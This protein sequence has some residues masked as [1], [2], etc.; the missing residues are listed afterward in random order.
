MYIFLLCKFIEKIKFFVTK[1]NYDKQ[2][3][4]IFTTRTITSKSGES[5]AIYAKYT[6]KSLKIKREG[7]KSTNS[8]TNLCLEI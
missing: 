7:N 1:K 4:F 8:M 5:L 2:Y 6:L 3:V